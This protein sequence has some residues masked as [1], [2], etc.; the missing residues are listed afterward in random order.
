MNIPIFL[1]WYQMFLEKLGDTLTT[2][3]DKFGFINEGNGAVFASSSSSSPSSS[4]APEAARSQNQRRQSLNAIPFQRVMA[5]K[6]Y[7]EGFEEAN[8]NPFGADD[9]VEE[10]GALS[11]AR[12]RSQSIV[13]FS[14]PSAT[15]RPR[16]KTHEESDPV[17]SFTDLVS[18]PV[19]TDVLVEEIFIA[20]C[21]Y[22]HSRDKKSNP[23][24]INNDATV[25]LERVQMSKKNFLAM[26]LILD[27]I[28]SK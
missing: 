14:S 16:N 12:H 26:C 6:T 25:P 3:L 7:Q 19:E 17:P 1:F 22:S 8:E 9:D 15:S 21:G 13:P 2:L 27:I 10:P 20:F 28:D 4:A 5:S 23:R 18:L 11:P 24:A